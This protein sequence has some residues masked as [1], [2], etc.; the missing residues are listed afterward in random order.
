MDLCSFLTTSKP[1]EEAALSMLSD[2]VF[3]ILP[4]GLWDELNFARLQLPKQ[5]HLTCWIL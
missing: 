4:D 3:E 2:P 5:L 1:H